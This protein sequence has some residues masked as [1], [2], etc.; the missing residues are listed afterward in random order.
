MKGYRMIKLY[1]WGDYVKVAE[2]QWTKIHVS[3][4]FHFCVITCDNGTNL[5]E[6]LGGEML[7]KAN[8][9]THKDKTYT[10]AIRRD[11]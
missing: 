5:Y 11:I 10:A 3:I 2:M 9:A 1:N 4:F 6:L 8:I 7:N